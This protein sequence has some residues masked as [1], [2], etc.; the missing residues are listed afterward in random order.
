MFLLDIA[1]S[2]MFQSSFPRRFWGDAILSA[3]YLINRFPSAILGWKT[4]YEILHQK[5]SSYTHL[6]TIGCLYFAIKP[7]PFQSKFDKRG[8]KCVLLDYPPAR[9]GYRLLEFD[10]N[11]IFTSRNVIFHEK[12]FPFAQSSPTTPAVPLPLIPLSDDSCSVPPTT[13]T[14]NGNSPAPPHSHPASPQSTSLTVPVPVRRSQRTHTKSVWL[15][16]FVCNLA[17]HSYVPTVT[18]FGS[19]FLDFDASLS[20]LQEPRSYKEAASFPHWVDAMDKELQALDLN[21]TWD[22]VP[23]PPGKRPIGCRWVYKVKLKDDGSI[24]RYKARL[25]AK[26]Y[27]QVEGV[28]Y[29][30]RFSPVAKAVTVRLFIAIATLFQWLLHQVDINN[31]FLYGHLDEEI[32]MSVPEGYSIQPG[33]VCLLRRSLYGLKQ[34]SR[35]W[36]LEFARSLTAFGFKQSEHDH[37]LFL[38]PLD[39]GFIGLLVYID[40]VLIMA[41]SIYFISQVK[42]HLDTLFTIKD[43]GSARYFLGLQIARSE[44]GTSLTQSKYISDIVADCG[45]LEAKTAA[46]PLPPGI[47]LHVDDDSLLEDPEPFRRLVGRLL[48]L[49]FTRPDISHGVQQ[50]S[51]FIQRPRRSHWLAATHLVRYLKGTSTHDLFFPASNCLQLRAF[52]DADW[53]ACPDTRRSLSGFCVFLGPALILWKT[54]KQCTVF[55]SSAEAECRSMA[56]TTCELKWISFLLRDFGITL[57]VP[58]PFYCNSQAV[59]HIMANQVFHERTKHLDIDCHIVR[60]C[61]KEGFLDPVFVRSKDQLADLVTKSLS[62]AQF[63]CLVRKLD[64]FLGFPSPT[65]GRGVENTEHKRADHGGDEGVLVAWEPD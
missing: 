65:C 6:R 22:V 61:Y 64:L 9:K 62:F 26:G 12:K 44:A 4:P 31:A 28:D 3:T 56:A 34:A 43:L 60:N 49:S 1:R 48:Y 14:S 37:C 42:L 32:Y 55:R 17:A 33:H 58:I 24:E 11:T 45:L 40:D 63:S 57:D 47:K 29:I 18:S 13:D 35:Q 38:K 52:C 20:A 36:N 5:V 59:L 41:P 30:E 39:S 46:T 53:A 7:S 10:S 16:D 23:L 51:Q 25:V 15:S 50:L 21:H 2:I 54:K 19:T 27:T 8:V